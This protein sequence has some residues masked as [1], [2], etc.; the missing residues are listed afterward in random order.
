MNINYGEQLKYKN[1]E[2]NQRSANE[3]SRLRSD[4]DH[5]SDST[6]ESAPR[7]CEMKETFLN[8]RKWKTTNRL[9]GDQ[10]LTEA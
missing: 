4:S 10:R 6:I 9:K 7:W 2:L 5:Q 3:P 8:S 1:K